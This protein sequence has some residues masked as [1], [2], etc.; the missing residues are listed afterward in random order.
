MFFVPQLCDYISHLHVFT[1]WLSVNVNRL[2]IVLILSIRA[3]VF[4]LVYTKLSAQP[5]GATDRGKRC[6]FPFTY[7]GA[8]YYRCTKTKHTALWCSTTKTYKGKWGNCQLSGESFYEIIT[9][10]SPES[11]VE[12]AKLAHIVQ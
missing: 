3:L 4:V 2:Q 9:K 8:K 1:T 10:L 12:I 5:G 6:V 11:T 7:L